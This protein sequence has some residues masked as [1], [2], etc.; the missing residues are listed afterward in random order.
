MCRC[1]RRKS[2]AADAY[3]QGLWN[4]GA[5]SPI[6]VRRGLFHNGISFTIHQFS[7]TEVCATS[8]VPVP[9]TREGRDVCDPSQ[10]LRQ[11]PERGPRSLRTESNPFDFAQGSTPSKSRGRRVPGTGQCR[12]GNGERRIQNEGRASF[13][14]SGFRRHSLLE[15]SGFHP[16]LRS[17]GAEDLSRGQHLRQKRT[18]PSPTTLKGWETPGS[19]D[20]SSNDH[21]PPRLH[22][23]PR[24]QPVVAKENVGISGTTGVS[25]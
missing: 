14:L 7:I 23:F 21:H 22:K 11:D 12:M 9:G 10:H 19:T 24:L 13:T 18:R 6:S 5:T 1:L 3:L 25:W 8:S 15:M 17:L 2:I 4:R 16:D 20:S